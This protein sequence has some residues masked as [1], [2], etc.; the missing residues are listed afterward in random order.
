M[1]DMQKIAM[2][3]HS[4]V[5]GIAFEVVN[6]AG[7]KK[8]LVHDLNNPNYK[9]SLVVRG[10]ELVL[11]VSSFRKQNRESALI[12]ALRINNRLLLD[13]VLNA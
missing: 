2:N 9:A 12:E 6:D 11:S 7:T 13:E 5:E 10:E 1:E 4:I 3:A 8:I